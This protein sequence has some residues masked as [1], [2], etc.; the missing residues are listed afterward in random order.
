MTITLINPTDR[1]WTRSRFVLAFG[2]HG[3][4][5]VMVWAN[6]L[7][8]ALEEAIDWIVDHAPGL[9]CDDEVQEEFDR[10][11]AEFPDRSEEDIA[12]EAE[13]DTTMFGHNGIHY[14]HSWE[15][16]IV[17]ENPSRKRVLALL[18]EY[19]GAEVAT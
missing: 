4:T 14:I 10:L 11:R 5:L 8:D 15:W 2:A 7:E 18:K 13:Q 1:H 19:G 9:L 6:H 3:D 16:T 12:E 17:A